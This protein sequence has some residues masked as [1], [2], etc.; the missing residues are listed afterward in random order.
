MFYFGITGQVAAAGDLAEA[1]F[2]ADLRAIGCT[3]YEVDENGKQFAIEALGGHFGGHMDGAALGIP[4]APKTW[5]VTEFKTHSAKSFAKLQKDG[6]QK[7]K[8]QHYAQMQIRS[9]SLTQ[10]LLVPE[11]EKKQAGVPGASESTGDTAFEM[12]KV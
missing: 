2:V 4:E 10:T 7:A 3:V 6:V 1:R 8:P 5:H 9:Y 11:R 12:M